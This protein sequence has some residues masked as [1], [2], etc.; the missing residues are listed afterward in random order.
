MHIPSHSPR[1]RLYEP[2]ARAGWLGK[3]EFYGFRFP[4]IAATSES[5]R[6]VALSHR[7]V[8]STLSPS[9]RLYEPEARAGL[10]K[11]RKFSHYK[12]R[13]QS[14]NKINLSV[15]PGKYR[16]LALLL[17]K[18]QSFKEENGTSRP[19]RAG[20]FRCSG[21]RAVSALFKAE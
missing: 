3:P 16:R 14:I 12:F 9:C 15:F 19:T 6:Q 10:S 2:E 5:S 7:G 21:K 4:I 20:M 17:T 8:G 11:K 18:D 13:F 1:R